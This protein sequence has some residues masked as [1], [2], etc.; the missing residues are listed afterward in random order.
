VPSA[1]IETAQAAAKVRIVVEHAFQ[2]GGI[3]CAIAFD[4]RRRLHDRR[5]LRIDLRG[6][7]FV[8]RN[9]LDTPMLHC[10]WPRTLAIA[11]TQQARLP[12]TRAKRLEG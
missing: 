6:I 1:S 11:S 10:R 12:A 7:E 3:I 2:V 9:C 5:R 4:H 8:P